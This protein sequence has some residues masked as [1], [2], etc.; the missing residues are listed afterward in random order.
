[1]TITIASA[2]YPI[3][4]HQDFSA[5]RDHVNNWVE[6]AVAQK[7]QLLVFPEY[8]SMELT[9]M[10]SADIQQNIQQQ[11]IE[12]SAVQYDFCTVWESLAKRHAI[13]I[14]APSIPILE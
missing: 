6:K 4:Y 14:V 13:T 12:L 9:S 10:M 5:W 8:G 2:Q 7:G 3:T 1:M 11:V